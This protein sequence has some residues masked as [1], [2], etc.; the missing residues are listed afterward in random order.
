MHQLQPHP[1]LAPEAVVL[2]VA[3]AVLPHVRGRGPWAAA[4]FGAA[5]LAATALTAPG[6]AAL[7]FVA[8]AWITSG[9]LALEPKSTT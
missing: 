2:A 4:G 8:A 9:V 7:P 5:L 1:A 3:A 6:A